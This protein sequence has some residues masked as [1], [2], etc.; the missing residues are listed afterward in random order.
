MNRLKIALDLDG[1]IANFNFSYNKFFN[2]DINKEEGFKI[3]KN[4][5]KL[6]HNK[7]FWTS[8]PI[9]GSINFTPYIYATKRINPKTYTKIWLEKNNFPIR[10]IYQTY[11]QNGNKA[12]IIKGRCDLII[13]DSISNF[14]DLNLSGVPCLLI[15]REYNKNWGP[16]GRIYSLDENEIIDC[17]N[18]FIRTMYPHFK[19]LANGYKEFIRH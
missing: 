10:P 4:V 12:D 19:E 18:L 15:D 6:R 2:T 13:D 8:L 11:Y 9:M 16:I 5:R 14:I 3:T 1:V 7:Q 17:Y